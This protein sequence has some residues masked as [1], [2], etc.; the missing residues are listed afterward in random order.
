MYKY[1]TKKYQISQGSKT[2]HPWTCFGGKKLNYPSQIKI[3]N[4]NNNTYQIEGVTFPAT[5]NSQQIHIKTYLCLPALVMSQF[6]DPSGRTSVLQDRRRSINASV[7]LK[8]IRIV[9]DFPE[10]LLPRRLPLIPCHP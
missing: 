8:N 7:P 6:L 3:L 2:C 9:K 10:Y 4:D 1:E 5:L